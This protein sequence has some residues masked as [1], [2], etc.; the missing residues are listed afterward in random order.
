MATESASA[1]LAGNLFYSG[2]VEQMKEWRYSVVVG[3]WWRSLWQCDAL[4]RLSAFSSPSSSQDTPTSLWT[5][6]YISRSFWSS[7]CFSKVCQHGCNTWPLP[8][9]A[10]D[11]SCCSALYLLQGVLILL[12]IGVPDGGG[13][14][15]EGTHQ[16]HISCPLQ[17]LRAALQVPTQEA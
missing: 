7:R 13:V 11:P 9:V 2:M 12:E 6:L 10:L 5:T 17:G 16:W 15:H 8:V 4:V 14:F 3:W 1:I